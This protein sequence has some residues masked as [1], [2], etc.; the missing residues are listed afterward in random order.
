MSAEIN[1]QPTDT[2]DSIA[3]HIRAITR[4]FG[5]R[6]V[7]DASGYRPMDIDAGRNT[8]HTTR[9]MIAIFSTEMLP[10]LPLGEKTRASLT[11]RISDDLARPDAIFVTHDREAQ[12]GWRD[13]PPEAPKDNMA[14][15]QPMIETSYNWVRRA[16]VEAQVRLSPEELERLANGWVVWHELGHA[17]QVSYSDVIA[18]EGRVGTLSANTLE[19]GLRPATFPGTKSPLQKLVNHRVE[20]EGFPEGFAQMLVAQYALSHCGLL[21]EE[22]ERFRASLTPPERRKHYLAIL[23]TFTNPDIAA[24]PATKELLDTTYELGGRMGYGNPHT[25]DQIRHIVAQTP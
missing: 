1:P 19:K 12:Y 6:Y 2:H 24:A 9:E 8:L 7:E 21:P 13:A 25:P 22:A 18:A 17:V 20:A 23:E 3:P 5:V 14:V 10:S 11:R 4:G 16:A 15:G